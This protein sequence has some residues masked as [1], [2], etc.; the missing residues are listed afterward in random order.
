MAAQTFALCVRTL[1]TSNT[2]CCCR[3]C[4]CC[5]HARAPALASE[6][7]LQANNTQRPT[8]ERKTHELPRSPPSPSTTIVIIVIN[9][10][11]CDLANHARCARAFSV[12]VRPYI[13]L[14]LNRRV[15][16][17]LV[18]FAVCCLYAFVCSANGRNKRA[19]VRLAVRST[20]AEWGLFVFL[21]NI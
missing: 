19:C 6:I 11:E 16:R 13:Q 12:L 8:I 1:Q 7:Y 20:P 9:I 5:L 14:L 3:S 15:V 17:T 10:A 2:P 18:L 21:H 4:C